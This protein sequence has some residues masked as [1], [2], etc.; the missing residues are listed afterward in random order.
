MRVFIVDVALGG[1]VG[2]MIYGVYVYIY[3]YNVVDRCLCRRDVTH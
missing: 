3:V 1:F 2:Y